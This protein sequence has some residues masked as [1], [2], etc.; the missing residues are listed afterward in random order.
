MSTRPGVGLPGVFRESRPKLL[1][2]FSIL[3]RGR[4]ANKPKTS[5]KTATATNF[6]SLNPPCFLSWYVSPNCM[7]SV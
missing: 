7:F 2:S 3:N 5:P 1:S 4:R 6:L